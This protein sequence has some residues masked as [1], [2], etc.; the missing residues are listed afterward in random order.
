MFVNF[1]KGCKPDK[2]LQDQ[3]LGGVGKGISHLEIWS[4][5]EEQAQAL[6]KLK[7]KPNKKNILH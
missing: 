6:V 5:N 2:L 4:L 1:V 7:W 3:E